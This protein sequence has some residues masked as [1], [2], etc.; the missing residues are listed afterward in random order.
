[1]TS[2]ET[3]SRG[4][5]FS[6]GLR[7]AALENKH[8]IAPRVQSTG[9]TIVGLVYKD[10]VVL[11]ADTRATAGSI[12]ADKNCKKIHHIS[13]NIWCAGAGTAADC[14][15][16]TSLMASNIELHALQS[17]RTPRVV[18]VMTMLKQY[19]FQYQ[20]HVGAYLVVGGY[21][22]TGPQLFTVHAHGSTDKL[23]YV[24]MG[25]GS[26]AAM[27]MFETNWRADMEEADA[28]ALV[29]KAIEAGIFNDLGSGSNVDIAVIRK[30]K[31]IIHRNYAKPNERVVKEQSYKF[32]RGTTAILKEDIKN[33][34]D[35]NEEAMELDS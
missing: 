12:V 30:D 1:M 19:L 32:S 3:Y 33:L 16:V 7:N 10:G 4:F 9:T 28:I 21:D 2:T 24:T 6:L 27:A 20:G 5:D 26:L 23:P 29:Q 34:V 17:G 8:N 31:T 25:S 22:P 14:D 35:I 11:G 18:T 13:P 15:F